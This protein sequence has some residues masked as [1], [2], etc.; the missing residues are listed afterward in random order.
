MPRDATRTFTGSGYIGGK[1]VMEF[2]GVACKE[3]FEKEKYTKCLYCKEKERCEKI[4]SGD[5]PNGRKKIINY[6]RN[7]T[8]VTWGAKENERERTY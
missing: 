4:L 8:V 7:C 5:I 1:K 2:A 3:R 6:K